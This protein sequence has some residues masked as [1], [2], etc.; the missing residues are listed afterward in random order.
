MNTFKVVVFFSN[1]FLLRV[2]VKYR[3]KDL[4]I[5][6]ISIIVHLIVVII[7]FNVCL[8]YDVLTTNDNIKYKPYKIIYTHIYFKHLILRF[9]SSIVYK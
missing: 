7:I 1:I 8:E 3:M 5:I 6:Q 9:I 4:Y 2:L